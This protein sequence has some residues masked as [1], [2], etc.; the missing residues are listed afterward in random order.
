MRPL[1]IPPGKRAWPRRYHLANEEATFV[2]EGRGR[3]RIGEREVAISEGDYAALPAGEAPDDQRPGRAA[4]LPGLLDDG[5]P[6]R[7]GLPGLEHFGGAA[8]GGPKERR[9]SSKF[10]KA[11]A[12][13]GYTTRGNSRP[14]WR[15]R[16]CRSRDNGYG[17]PTTIDT[18]SWQARQR[19]PAAVNP[20]D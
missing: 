20:K 18:R 4:A 6:R 16:D 2:L 13:A 5:R 10:L 1:Q 11:D 19:K 9:T 3:L 8:P 7:H 15:W 12:E 17:M 14:A